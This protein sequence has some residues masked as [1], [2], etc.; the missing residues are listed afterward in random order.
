M[1]G[2]L[3][4]TIYMNL[5]Q[6]EIEHRSHHAHVQRYDVEEALRAARR[7]NKPLYAPA[8]AAV[9]KLL[10][11]LGQ[12]LEQRYSRRLA[13]VRDTME[14]LAVQSRPAPKTA[15]TQSY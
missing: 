5:R 15:D 6:Q 1:H 2:N 9:G 4:N 12:G 3:Q 10:I 14:T 11:N 8:L 7:R 13:D